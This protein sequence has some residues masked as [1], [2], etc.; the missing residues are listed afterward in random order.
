MNRRNIVLAA[1]GAAPLVAGSQPAR[2]VPALG[3]TIAQGVLLRA[4]EVIR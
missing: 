3:L 1:L 4:D 2:K